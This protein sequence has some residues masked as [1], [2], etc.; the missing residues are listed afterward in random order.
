MWSLVA[1]MSIYFL[2]IFLIVTMRFH[3]VY[4]RS[5]QVFLLFLIVLGWNSMI[6]SVLLYSFCSWLKSHD[7]YL[8]FS[9]LSSALIDCFRWSFTLFCCRVFSAVCTKILTSFLSNYIHDNLTLF[10]IFNCVWTCFCISQHEYNRR[11]I[12]TAIPADLEHYNS[13]WPSDS[14]NSTCFEY[15]SREQPITVGFVMVE[16]MW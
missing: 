13:T 4:L 7:V 1:E 2:G 8:A 5:L 15:I 9:I 3:N 16:S 12:Y 14:I 11:L 6:F 10:S